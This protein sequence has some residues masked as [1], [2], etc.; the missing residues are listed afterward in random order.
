MFLANSS[1]LMLDVARFPDSFR[2]PPLA[3]RLSW[4]S[5]RLNVP[6]IRP[7]QEKLDILFAGIECVVAVALHR[8]RVAQGQAQRVDT[9]KWPGACYLQ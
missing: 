5:G 8:S 3:L 4:R 6:K 2:R 7:T 9:K 1:V